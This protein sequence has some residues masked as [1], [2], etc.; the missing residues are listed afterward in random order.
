MKPLD[1]YIF[2]GFG[3]VYFKRG[4]MIRK[5]IKENSLYKGFS[6]GEADLIPLLQ[7]IQAQ[8]GY[9]SDESLKGVAQFLRISENRIYGVASFY[10][11]FR[12]IPPGRNSIRVCLGTACH[13]RGGQ[14][15]SDLVERQLV[16]LPGET[17]EDKRFDYDTV[18]CLGCC[19]LSP[20][21]MINK[22]IYSRMN[23]IR[24]N[25]ILEKYE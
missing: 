4:C 8:E 25:Q 22:D 13:V 3:E 23:V 6:G 20:V 2:L 1:I 14:T 19:A 11:Q 24:L 10:T 5:K 17:T 16:V 7:R 12:F 15:L 21:V 9:I 18:A